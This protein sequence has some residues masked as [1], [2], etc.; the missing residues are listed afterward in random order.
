VF[1]AELDHGVEPER[2]ARSY[3]YEIVRPLS[4]HGPLEEMKLMML[5]KPDP[6]GARPLRVRK[7]HIEPGSLPDSE[8]PKRQRL[9]A[10]GILTSELGLLAVEFS[11]KTRF[12]GQ[13]GLPGGGIDDGEKAIDAAQRE[14]KEE[15]GQ[16]ASKMR[17]VDLQTEHWVG[18]A[19]TGE[20]E[21][22][23]AVR[24]VYRGEVLEPGEPQVLEVNGTTSVARWIPLEGWEDHPWTPAARALLEKHLG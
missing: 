11:D 8:P 16:S 7:R 3:G 24:I 15:T 14:I 17:L 19:P 20:V 10:Y 18:R 13:W 4:V 9:A 1:S 2:L 5:V 22:F 6:R 21:D 12:F 23:Q